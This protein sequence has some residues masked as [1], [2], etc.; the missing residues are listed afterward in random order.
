MAAGPSLRVPP[1]KFQSIGVGNYGLTVPTTVHPGDVLILSTDDTAYTPA[2]WTQLF[3]GTC[4]KVAVTA[5]QA[6]ALN[7]SSYAGGFLLVYKDAAATTPLITHGTSGTAPAITTTVA[8]STVAHIW[9]ASATSPTSLTLPTVSEGN[10][11]FDSTAL[12]IHAAYGV[13]DVTQAA[14]GLAVTKT[15]TGTSSPTFAAIS[16]VIFPA[17]VPSAPVLNLPAN[18]SMGPLSGTPAFSWIP[19]P[20]NG[21]GAMNAYALRIKVVGAGSYSYWN[22]STQL[23]QGSIVWNA[24]AANS[25]TLAASTLSDSSDYVWSVA[26]QESSY[27]GQGPFASDYTVN[28][29][30]APTVT[31]TAP[32]LTVFTSNPTVTWTDTVAAGTVETGYRAIVY[33]AAQ[34]GAG[35]FVP[36]VGPSAWDSG[37]VQPYSTTI[38]LPLGALPNGT[39]RVYLQITETGNVASAWAFSGFAVQIELPATPSLTATAGTDP[40]TSAPLVALA[41]QGHDNLLSSVDAAFEHPLWTP[42]PI[43]A[44]GGGWSATGTALATLAV[45]PTA[46]GDLIVLAGAAGDNG[47]RGT[48]TVSGGGVT[49]WT[50]IDGIL[51]T[52]PISTMMWFGVVTTAGASTI[53]VTGGSAATATLFAQQFS[54]G[55]PAIWSLDTLGTFFAFSGGSATSGPYA[56]VPMTPAGPSELCVGAAVLPGGTLGGSS[57]GFTYRSLGNGQFIFN[58]SISNPNTYNPGWT[59][60][61][62]GYASALAFLI[63]SNPA[64]VG[65]WTPTNA[66]LAQT[67]TQAEEGSFSMSMEANVPGAGMSAV[68]TPYPI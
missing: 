10:F 43:T 41:L 9:Q 34:Y 31:V 45:H 36:G 40:V 48:E 25:V 20:T 8:A 47:F 56:T 33:N 16:L 13:S 66:A 35:G 29:Q 28:G 26:T 60:A 57:P 2:G 21:D 42:G 62:A 52:G 50:L 46:V 18:G 68:T 61:S 5:D 53:T 27:N 15:A 49:T 14:S 67:L 44:V 37:N 19:Q 65:T 54:V 64:G 23:L 6:A 30:V 58:P 4:W 17:A 39:Y 7:V 3:A 63:P 1:V 32:T 11:A 51:S 24:S 12:S 38:T 22:A 59:Q 55:I